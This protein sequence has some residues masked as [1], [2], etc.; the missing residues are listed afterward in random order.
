MGNTISLGYIVDIILNEQYENTKIH[1]KFNAIMS[2]RARR[3]CNSVT[4]RGDRT[5]RRAAKRPLGLRG[6]SF[7]LSWASNK[8]LKDKHD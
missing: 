3:K 1:K 6:M 7:D 5:V 2:S 4:Q 8:S